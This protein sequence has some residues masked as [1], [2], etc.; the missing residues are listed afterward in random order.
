MLLPLLSY[1]ILCKYEA[2]F[3]NFKPNHQPF[4]A[5]ATTLGFPRAKSWPV[6]ADILLNVNQMS[7]YRMAER[8]FVY[9]RM[10][11]FQGVTYLI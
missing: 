2:L 7:T 3:N 4:S 5:F 11:M 1:L 10:H 9:K 8:K 6:L